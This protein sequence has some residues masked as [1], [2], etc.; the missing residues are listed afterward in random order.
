MTN[1]NWLTH[2]GCKAPEKLPEWVIGTDEVGTGALAG[3]MWVVAVAAPLQWTVEG[4]RDSK[5]FTGPWAHQSRSSL[6]RYI[7]DFVVTDG[8]FHAPDIDRLGAGKA[9][10]LLHQTV[11]NEALEIFPD[12]LVIV[13]GN[14]P[15]EKAI[16]LPKADAKVP[17][18]MAASIFAKVQRDEYMMQEMHQKYPVYDFHIHKGYGTQKH[19]EALEKYGPCEIHRRSYLKGKSWNQSKSL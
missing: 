15:L 10:K 1:I 8:L 2:L 19:Y 7:R 9:I 11:I 17:V 5:Q 13:D 12:A 16:S 6:I 3:P 18:C 4:L 14:L